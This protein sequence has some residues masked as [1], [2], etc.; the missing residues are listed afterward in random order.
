MTNIIITN[1]IM[2]Y[3]CVKFKFIDR[4][5]DYEVYAFKYKQYIILGL[6]YI[7]GSPARRVPK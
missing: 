5:G 3:Y 2:K 7:K 4:V 6:T 1:I